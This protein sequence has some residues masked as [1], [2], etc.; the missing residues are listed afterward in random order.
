MKDIAGKRVAILVAD[1]FEQVEMTE[2][3]KALDQA[4]VATFIVSPAK[5]EVKGANHDKPGDS[6]KVD[7]SLDEARES[8][9]DALLIP[10]GVMSPD[11]LRTKPQAV[12]LVKAFFSSGKPIFAICHGPWMLVEAGIVK[13]KQF[14][15]YPSI[16]TDLKNAGANWIDQE[17]VVDQGIVTSRNPKDIPAFNMKIVEELGEGIHRRRAA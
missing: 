10:G 6:F 14:T 1:N 7:Q 16:K 11:E 3:R 13:G 8:D 12:N 5:G 15:S 17:V 2:P 9:Y 4:G